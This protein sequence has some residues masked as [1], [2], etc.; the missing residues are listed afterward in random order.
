MK[1]G[2]PRRPK[3]KLGTVEKNISLS[4]LQQYYSG[5]LK[6]AAKSIGGEL[7]FST[8]LSCWSLGW[9]TFFYY[10]LC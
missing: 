2:S 1:S 5:T 4:V 9:D 7:F 8:L 6:D 10:W 3:K